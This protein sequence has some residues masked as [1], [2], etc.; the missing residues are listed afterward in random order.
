[1][2]YFDAHNHLQNFG[3]EAELDGAM[4][5]AAAAGVEGM[6]CCGTM[7]DDWGRVLEIAGRYSGVVP[8]FGLHPW[9]AAEEG[10]QGKLE[11]FLRRAPNACVGECGL[12]GL[13]SLPGQ[14]AD[15]EAQL[16]LA[17]RFNRP[18]IVHCVKS[19][20]RAL[21]LLKAARLP[22]FMLH[23]YGGSPELAA[24]FAALG[25]YFSFGR[26]LLDSRRE[27]TRLALA[28]VPRE[29]LLLETEA[30]RPD[31]PGP[32]A[33]PAG[34]TEVAAAAAAALGLP[35]A[36]LAELSLVNA[37]KFTGAAI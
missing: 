16:E 20:G 7:P 32:Q 10:W 15:F 29:R 14:E 35:A 33:G 31:A 12:D 5:A 27:K 8:C 9:F 21:E 25:S 3:S 11:E 36:E 28:A 18:A 2:K 17:A 24:Q 23:G 34:I 4:R 30:P 1:M 26:E 22:R 6:L 37:K 13:K 19:W